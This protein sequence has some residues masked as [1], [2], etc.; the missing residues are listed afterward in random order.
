MS[1]GTGPVTD[2]PFNGITMP[3]IVGHEQ[4]DPAKGFPLPYAYILKAASG[5]SRSN[6][7]VEAVDYVLYERT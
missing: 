6:V 3:D 1:S 5:R 7:P 4:R 2:D